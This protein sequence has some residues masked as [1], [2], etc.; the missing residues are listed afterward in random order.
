MDA[1]SQELEELKDE[2]DYLRSDVDRLKGLLVA[3]S[4][5]KVDEIERRNSLI[6]ELCD[7]LEQVPVNMI[8]TLPDRELIQRAREATK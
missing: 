7:A 6:T 5:S 4:D 3:L 8:W 2:V 1:E